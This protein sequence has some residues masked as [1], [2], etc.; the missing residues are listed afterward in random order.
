MQDRYYENVEGRYM[1]LCII[2]PSEGRRQTSFNRLSFL[3]LNGAR[4]EV[5]STPEINYMFEM[6]LFSVLRL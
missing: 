3:Q 6:S 5:K 4:A 2:K 1:T